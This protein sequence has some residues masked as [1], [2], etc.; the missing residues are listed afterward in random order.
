MKP[1]LQRHKWSKTLIGTRTHF[2]II[3]Y[4]IEKTKTTLSQ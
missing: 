2:T 1:C 4:E 3:K